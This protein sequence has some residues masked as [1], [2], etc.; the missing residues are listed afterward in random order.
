MPKDLYS[1]AEAA[2]IFGVKRE[3]FYR[4]VNRGTVAR[5]Y[6]G[7]VMCI[8]HRSLC[9]LARNPGYLERRRSSK[10]L[11]DICRELGIPAVDQGRLDV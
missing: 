2:E 10:P 11:A 9:D 6:I 4:L 8:S 5:R 3:A 1:L 7:R